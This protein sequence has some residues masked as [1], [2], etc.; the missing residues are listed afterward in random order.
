MKIYA[1]PSSNLT[2]IWAGIGAGKWA[3]SLSEH[4]QVNKRRTTLSADMP[5]GSFGILYCS[6]RGLTTPFVIYSKPE[7]G[8]FVDDVWPER[9][10]LPFDIKPLG[11]PTK[12]MSREDAVKKLPSIALRGLKN[13]DALIYTKGTQTFVPSEISD[14]DWSVLISELAI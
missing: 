4:D 13:V 2:N 9:W 8:E 6:G 10:T 3:V 12:L 11:N 5:I 14:D 7:L 1:F